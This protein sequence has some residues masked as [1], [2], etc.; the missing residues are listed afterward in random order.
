MSDIDFDEIDK[1]VNNAL[2]ASPIA[3]PEPPQTLSST[4]DATPPA[5]E[6]PT[7]LQ[8]PTPSPA[9]APVPAARRSSGMFMDMVHPSS[10]MRGRPNSVAPRPQ[11]AADV[12]PTPLQPA[13]QIATLNPA[14]PTVPLESASNLP[15]PTANSPTL[16]S[17]F[18]PDAKVEKRPLGGAATPV[19]EIGYEESP[20]PNNLTDAPSLPD[21][22]NSPEA[23]ALLAA[24]ESE[25]AL[26]PPAP[27]EMLPSPAPQD[28]IEAPEVEPLVEA[29]EAE[30]LLE[31]EQP[32]ESSQQLDQPEQPQP[33]EPAPA[34][35]SQ[36]QTLSNASI[37]QQYEEKPSSVVESGAIY[38]T[39]HYHQP[40]TPAPK[41]KTAAIVLLWVILLI[42]AGAAAG[43]AFYV[44]V[45][46]L[47]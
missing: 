29:P 10:V 34:V 27:E 45:L 43:A 16:E 38:D 25:S 42:I 32:A 46:P 30:K 24:V 44:Y 1:A 3:S 2:G 5:L 13:P 6:Q 28:L 39:E 47:L 19:G 26:P 7:Q 21:S 9:Q 22:L 17:P 41:K 12:K 40:I 11:P 36:A 23:E 37:S 33:A 18:L 35:I 20:L 14:E 15:E 8:A 4:P 31:I